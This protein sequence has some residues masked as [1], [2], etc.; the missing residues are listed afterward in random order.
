MN[1]FDK[2][3]I[4]NLK[5]VKTEFA[6]V[7]A[8]YVVILLLSNVSLFINPGVSIILLIALLATYLP[9]YF[10]YRKLFY[11]TVYGNSATLFNQLPVTKEEVV[12]GKILVISIIA[13]A[14]EIV[15]LAG[16]KFTGH[17]VFEGIEGALSVGNF[18]I[19]TVSYVAAS[20]ATG[21]LLFFVIAFYHLVPKA[22]RGSIRLPLSVVLF[23]AL[24]SVNARAVSLIAE[25]LSFEN[26]NLISIAE[27]VLSMVMLTAS[28]YA[29]VKMLKKTDEE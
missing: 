15:A 24:E 17:N 23:I 20:A 22:E 13:L 7:I 5:L 21:S 28:A 6:V 27:A 4:E 18:A 26:G 16:F 19:E 10:A 3:V 29:T 25:K 8:A 14:V 2:Y 9:L 11:D 12:A 1:V